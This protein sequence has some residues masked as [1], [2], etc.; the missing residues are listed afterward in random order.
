MSIWTYSNNLFYYKSVYENYRCLCLPIWNNNSW[1]K[2]NDKLRYWTN[3]TRNVN[4][5]H[6]ECHKYTTYK[7]LWKLKASKSSN[8][9]FLRGGKQSNN[10]RKYV[11]NNTPI[12]QL[13]GCQWKV[14]NEEKQAILSLL[15]FMVWD[16]SSRFN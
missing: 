14:T 3:F 13:F 7:Y 15:Q 12:I 9:E 4:I 10:T 11:V 1:Y 2:H 6:G 8:Q 16:L 5:L